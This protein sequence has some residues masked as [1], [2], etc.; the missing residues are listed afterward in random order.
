[1]PPDREPNI[2]N[3][4]RGLG[5]HLGYPPT[6]DLASS[7]RARLD[8]ERS[9]GDGR[10][11]RL[12]AWTGWAVAAALLLLV[13]VPVLSLAVRGGLG[14]GGMAGG[15]AES[16]RGDV[17]VVR[18]ERAGVP[19]PGNEPT[20]Y[21]QGAEAGSAGAASVSSGEAASAYPSRGGRPPLGEG[22]GLGERTTL[23]EARTRSEAAILFARSPR[24][25]T[26]DEAYDRAGVPGFTLLYRERYRG[27]PRLPGLEDT[28]VGLILTQTPGDVG[29]A[30][31]RGGAKKADLEPVRINGETGYWVPASGTGPEVARSAGLFA[32]VLLW[33]RYGQALRLEAEVSKREAVR[34]AGSVR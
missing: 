26:P 30:Y 3:E 5:P 8:A 2:E 24:L 1:M 4:L 21:A 16:G 31:L 9:R 20:T 28:R 32:G 27:R 34:I 6:P 19:G 33:E 12:P 25:G 22:L 18:D 13:A 11:R 14:A 15:A 10:D 17:T 29:A 7:V 23:R